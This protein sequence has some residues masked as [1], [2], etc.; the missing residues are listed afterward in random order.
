[1]SRG[2][3]FGCWATWV[4]LGDQRIID[5]VGVCSKVR[6]AHVKFPQQ[7]N[8][9][10]DAEGTKY[11]GVWGASRTPCVLRCFGV[12]MRSNAE[13]SENVPLSSMRCGLTR[14]VAHKARKISKNIL[15][16]HL[17]V[18]RFKCVKIT[19]NAKKYKYFSFIVGGTF[20]FMAKKDVFGAIILANHLGAI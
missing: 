5:R 2:I 13:V 6:T 17:G 15:P 4:R 3:N 1:M 16:N 18:T 14:F 19:K 20:R 8:H 10:N 9:K 7:G 12:N 11:F